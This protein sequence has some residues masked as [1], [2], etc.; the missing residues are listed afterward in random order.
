MDTAKPLLPISKLERKTKFLYI[1]GMVYTLVI[2]IT[3]S[4]LYYASLT[5]SEQEIKTITP[6]EKFDARR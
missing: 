5:L 1:L 2:I 6:E 3:A 4:V